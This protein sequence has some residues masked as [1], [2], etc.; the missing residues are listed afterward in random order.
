MLKQLGRNRHIKE[1]QKDAVIKVGFLR[2]DFM[3]V[4]RNSLDNEHV[5]DTS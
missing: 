4:P 3:Y 5:H 2:T 1:G